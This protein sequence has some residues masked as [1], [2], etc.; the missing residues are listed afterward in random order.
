MQQWKRIWSVLL[1]GLMV[2]ALSLTLVPERALAADII[3]TGSVNANRLNLRSGA[4][5]DEHVLTVLD[6]G[7][8]VRVLG[9]S[10]EWLK[11]EAV[12]QGKTGYVLAR[13]IR[14][15]AFSYDALGLGVVTGSV[16]FRQKA[17]ASSKSLDILRRGEPVILRAKTAGGWY[18][19]RIPESGEEG[20]VSGRYVRLVCEMPSGGSGGGAA[21]DGAPGAINARRV[22]LRS[23][24]STDYKSLGRL[25]EG[26]ALY[27]LSQSG[28]WY[29]VRIKFSGKTGYIHRLYVTLSGIP[30]ETK[31]EAGGAVNGSGVNLRSGPSTDYK[32]LGKLKKGTLLTILSLC[33]NWYQ[34]RVNSTGETGYMYKKYVTVAP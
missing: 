9:V 13:Y 10:G 16:H 20:Y 21:E 19:V 17:S 28:S 30:D 6:R 18:Q 8:S 7:D 29:R 4:S 32:S 12:D 25:D 15:N 1:C 31:K 24:P 26:T 11:V 14:L 23:G 3:A 2:F 5:T 22:N 27:V 33:G 34:V